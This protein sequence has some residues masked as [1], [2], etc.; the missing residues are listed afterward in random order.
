MSNKLA[1]TITVL[2]K[3]LM[4]AL[5]LTEISNHCKNIIYSYGRDL[6]ALPYVKDCLL[7]SGSALAARKKAEGIYNIHLKILIFKIKSYSL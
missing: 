7:L 5:L 4:E 2:L 3:K 1:I 6:V